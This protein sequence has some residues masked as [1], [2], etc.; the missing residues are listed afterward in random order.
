MRK[1]LIVN[2]GT[3]RPLSAPARSR[4][5]PALFG[6]TPDN[7]RIATSENAEM[8]FRALKAISWSSSSLLDVHR[9]TA[10]TGII[11]IR[12][13][14]YRK[15]EEIERLTNEYINRADVEKELIE[16]AK[17]LA[18]GWR[19]KQNPMLAPL[20]DSDGDELAQAERSDR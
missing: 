19:A 16:V 6:R 15:L 3:G 7:S 1:A 17:K 12:L 13:D 5:K 10:D 2:I 8:P 18:Q 11:D 14:D 4:R 9:F 20:H